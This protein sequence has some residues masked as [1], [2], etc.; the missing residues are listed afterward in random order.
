MKY[1]KCI[2]KF[3]VGKAVFCGIDVH[4]HHWDLCYFSDGDVVERIKIPSEVERLTSHTDRFYQSA[5]RIKFVYEAGF[6]GFY[7]YRRLVESGYSCMITPP[8]RVPGIPDKVKTN[9]RDAENLA[10]L[11]AGGF[12]KEVFV[13][14]PAAESD[15]QLMRLRDGY[16]RK[17]S[18]VKNQI[19]SHLNLQG[20]TWPLEKKG[21]KWTKRYLEWLE[22]LS[23]AEPHLA[24]ILKQYLSEYR[25]FRG[26]IADLTKRIRQLS[27]SEIYQANFKR[28]TAC[29]GVG[30]ITAMTFLLELPEP[31]RFENTHAFSS[32]IGMTPSQFSSGEHVHM[33]HI[34]RE[35]NPHLRRVLV[36]SA[37]SVIR[38]DPFLREKY[39]RIRAKGT[40]G[41]KAI[42][43]VARSLAIRLRRCLLDEVPYTIG[44]C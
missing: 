26:Q 29:K 16:Q 27:R 11:L 30:L 37:W 18:R 35:G 20:V 14:K 44:I 38:H 23:F 39:D 22:S 36:E 32:Y 2:E 41:K 5:S 9:K 6:S 10:R 34:T 25:F 4:K 1:L 31:S 42:V 7:L 43:A 40:N 24:F 12:L 17:L 21:A 33:G 13:P 19:K 28:L 15:R 3:V 8:N